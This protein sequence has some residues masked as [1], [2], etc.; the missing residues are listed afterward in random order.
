MER[1][2]RIA[3]GVGAV[4]LLGL[5]VGAFFLVRYFWFQHHS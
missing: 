5:A 4:V 2:H 1:H 3:Q